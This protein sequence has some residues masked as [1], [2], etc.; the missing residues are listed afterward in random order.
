MFEQ[1]RRKSDSLVT[2]FVLP[3]ELDFA[4]LGVA[5]A[6]RHGNAVRRNR[7]KR[8]A[9]EAFR[10]MRNE[11]PAGWDYMVVP[12]VGR[13]F[14]LENLQRSI[15]NLSAALTTAAQDKGKIKNT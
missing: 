5:V 10:L 12:R 9:R 1:G 8:L 2:L 3:N 13:E 6:T 7:V 15:R 14:T 4:R 11:L